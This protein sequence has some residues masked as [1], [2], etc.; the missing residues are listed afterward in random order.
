MADGALRGALVFMHK[1]LPTCALLL[2]LLLTVRICK[3]SF[4][5]PINLQSHLH[6][7]IKDKM[8]PCSQRIHRL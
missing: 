8:V 2:L 3:C 1:H 5:T 4:L 6:S 7:K